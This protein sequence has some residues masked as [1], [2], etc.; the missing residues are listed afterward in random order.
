MTPTTA[1]KRH[2]QKLPSAGLA[3]E[4]LREKGQ[5]WTP[6]WVANAMVQYVL[7]NGST[8]IFDPA[9]GPGIFFRSAKDIAGRQGRS[10]RL[11]GTEIDAMVLQQARDLGLAKKDIARVELRDFVLD[12][13]QGQFRAIVANPPYIRHHRISEDIKAR[14]QCLAQSLVGRRLDGR[15]G[16]HIYFLLR[17]LELLAPD[18]RLAFIMPADTVEGVFAGVLWRWAASKYRLEAV[19]TFEHRASPF[20]GVDTNPLIFMIQNSAPVKHFL[21][22]RCTEPGGTSLIEWVA[23]GFVKRA[24]SGLTVQERSLV[25]GLETGLSRPYNPSIGS[26]AVLGDFARV[27]RGI[28]TGANEFFHITVDQARV[29]KIPPDFLVPA[30]GR[31]RDVEGELLAPDRIRTLEQVGR[32]TLL[33]SPDGRPIEALPPAVREYIRQGERKGFHRK[34]LVAMRRPWYKMEVRSAPPFLFAYLGRRNARFIRNLAGVCPLTGFLCVYPRRSD[35]DF[36]ERLWEVL[37]QP[38]TINGLA[39]VGKSYG[40]GAIKVEPRALEKLPLP[41]SLVEQAGLSHATASNV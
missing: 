5:F 34:P 1:E 25:E 27:L 17:A 33:F 24:L 3:R 40:G 13:P 20:P 41:E 15:A 39:A 16:L 23:S 22:A 36:I 29:L 38:E 14:L 9:V 10:V 8:S 37:R 30:I 7:A 28:A 6:G 19:V 35:P 18:G 32:P 21:W 31:T 2:H 4:A 12:P 11:L 26:S